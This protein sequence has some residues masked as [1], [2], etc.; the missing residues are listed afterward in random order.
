[1][2]LEAVEVEHLPIAVEERV[3]RA[4]RDLRTSDDLAG[5]VDAKAKADIPSEGDEVLERAGTIG[6]RQE[7]AAPAGCP[8]RSGDL[9]GV[10]NGP[11]DALASAEVDEA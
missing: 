4:A 3:V 2:S 9:A 8:R 7:R 10:V 6:A 1:V 11:A 5:V